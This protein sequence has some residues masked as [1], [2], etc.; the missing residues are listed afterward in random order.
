[1]ARKGVFTIGIGGSAVREEPKSGWSFEYPAWRIYL[2]PGSW[3]SGQ[4]WRGSPARRMTYCLPGEWM[5]CV[6]VVY[7]GSV[8]GGYPY[9]GERELV[10]EELLLLFCSWCKCLEVHD[11]LIPRVLDR[12]S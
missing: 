7:E 6:S 3:R 4:T 10:D 12:W 5:S 8:G 1:M 11:H 2:R 9:K